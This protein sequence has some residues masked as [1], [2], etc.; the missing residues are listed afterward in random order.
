MPLY[1]AELLAKKPLWHGALIHDV[2]QVL[3]L[4]FDYDDGSFARDRSGYNNHGTIYGAT[5]VAGK[6]GMARNL[7]GTDDYVEVPDDPSLKPTSAMSLQVW[8]KIT[9]LT[10]RRT[11]AAKL[12]SGV[13]GWYAFVDT[14]G[15]I[16]FTT[17]LKTLGW[18]DL[19][20][21]TSLKTDEWYHLALVFGGT[22]KRI[23]INGEEDAVATFGSDEIEPSVQPFHV[24]KLTGTTYY[25]YG[26]M[27]EVRFARRIL[28]R[29]E[30]PMLMYRRI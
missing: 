13:N 11:I 17:K 21:A 26:I 28:S 7:D 9:D 2:S 12:E 4:P 15:K 3:Y 16:K 25:F 19:F 29:D 22:F 6:I 20:S 18:H 27:D 30:V 8:I 23:Y 1:R 14:T 24:A 5:L 10:E